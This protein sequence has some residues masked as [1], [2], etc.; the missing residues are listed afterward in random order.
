MI[1]CEKY[2]LVF[3]LQRDKIGSCVP[4]KKSVFTQ[5][6]TYYLFNYKLGLYALLQIEKGNV[7]VEQD[8]APLY[9]ANVVHQFLNVKLAKSYVGRGGW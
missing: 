2:I 5:N 3:L 4:E 7:I 9:Y 6:V 8:G 1:P